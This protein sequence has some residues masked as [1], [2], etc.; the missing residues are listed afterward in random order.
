MEP[1]AKRRRHSY[2]FVNE[3]FC[4]RICHLSVVV[5]QK[6]LLFEQKNGLMID[7]FLFQFLFFPEGNQIGGFVIRFEASFCWIDVQLNRWLA[8]LKGEPREKGKE[9]EGRLLYPSH[10]SF[11]KEQSRRFLLGRFFQ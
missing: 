2:L 10:L 3:V 1:V 5:L 9:E 7:F 6:D 11:Q 4:D 8:F